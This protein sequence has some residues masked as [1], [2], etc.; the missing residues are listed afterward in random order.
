MPE[1]DDAA[2]RSTFASP[3]SALRAARKGNPRNLPYPTCKRPGQL[4]PADAA[5]GYQCDG[6]ADA[7]EG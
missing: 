2:R 7:E 6:C 3:G 1:S 4:T 5:R